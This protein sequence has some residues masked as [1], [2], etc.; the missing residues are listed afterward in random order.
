MTRP[1]ILAKITEILSEV[2][3]NDHLRLSETTTADSV[4]NWDSIN[5]VKLL[6]GLENDLGIQFETDEVNSVANVG[7][8]IDVIQSKLPG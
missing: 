5:H 4:E 3:D 7:G 8:L 1:E 2:L 6:I